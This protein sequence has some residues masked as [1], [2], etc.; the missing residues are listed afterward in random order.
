[1]SASTISRIENGLRRLSIDHLVTLA[2]ALDTTIDELLVDESEDGP[3]IRPTKDTASGGMVWLLG[4]RHDPGGRVIAKM[5]LP[6]SKVRE[7]ET[8]VHPGR[9][10]FYVLEGT[11]R[12]VLGGR[13]HHVEAGNAAAFDTMTPHAMLGYGGSAEILTIF[14]HHGDRAHLQPPGRR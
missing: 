9:D 5:R 8:R 6:A 4:G 12:L 13:E 10:W 2:A 1:M 7:P 11:V 3:V 14:D